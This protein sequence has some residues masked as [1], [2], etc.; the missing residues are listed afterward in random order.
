M[1]VIRVV[2]RWVNYGLRVPSK[3]HHSSKIFFRKTHAKSICSIFP[4]CM[5]LN[6]LEKSSHKSE[7]CLKIFCTYSFNDSTDGQNLWGYGTISSKA[8]LIFPKNF[9]NFRSDMIEKRGIINVSSYRSKSYTSVVLC[10]SGVVCFREG[11][12]RAFCPLCF[13]YIQCCIVNEVCH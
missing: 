13:G 6:V 11:R 3:Y 1:K 7:G 8:I 2:I 4:Q 12:Y 5:A 10:N 9:L